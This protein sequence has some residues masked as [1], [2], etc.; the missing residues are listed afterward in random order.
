MN[1]SEQ[2]LSPIRIVLPH[3]ARIYPTD[4]RFSFSKDDFDY[5]EATFPNDVASDLK[6]YHESFEFNSRM[7]A[8]VEISVG[9]SWERVQRMHYRPELFKGG[10]ARQEY[11][12]GGRIELHDMHELLQSGVVDMAP[13]RADAE[14]VY[15]K[16]LDNFPNDSSKTPFNGFYNGI[17]VQANPSV[18]GL[19][20][21]NFWT[22]GTNNPL[23]DDTHTPLVF[24]FA[25]NIEQATPLEAIN[26]ANKKFNLRT[27]FREDGTFVVGGYQTR[28]EWTAS[29]TSGDG[30]LHI[31]NGRLASSDGLIDK[32]VIEGPKYFPNV[33]KFTTSVV[34]E[35]TFGDLA[36]VADEAADW[37][38]P[39]DNEEDPT[40][41]RL[42]A[43]IN[44]TN[45]AK[46]EG[47][48]RKLTAYNTDP[49]RLRD[50]GFRMFRTLEKKS[51][52]GEI[53]I[54][55][56]S[57]KADPNIRI[58]DT[59]DV[60]NITTCG[61]LVDPNYDEGVYLVAGVE[62]VWD[63]RWKVHVDVQDVPVKKNDLKKKQRI[64]DLS[65]G[66]AFTRTQ[67]F[68]YRKEGLERA[69]EYD[70]GGFLPE[71]ISTGDNDE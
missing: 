52:G 70:A 65:D 22:F 39:W 50:I 46:G 33:N 26:Q 36:R 55:G 54:D 61:D 29:N 59:I 10:I 48:V 5:L 31:T 56:G 45:V 12:E 15:G 4:L 40:G 8:E 58:G 30:Q 19:E 24:N 13:D 3:G 9:D 68:L 2:D 32:L 18:S 27:H 43:V 14:F 38:N 42:Q 37:L 34:D 6:K 17:D 7:L 57:S 49:Q 71:G 67:R 41:Y 64:L 47:V 28:N 66:R 35:P 69:P 62:H 51:G 25:I 53:V 23:K 20:K 16:I 11:E 21:K 1:C 44:N 60:R 63:G